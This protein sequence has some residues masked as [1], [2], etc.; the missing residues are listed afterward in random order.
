MSREGLEG[1]QN[2]AWVT[3]SAWRCG[4]LTNSVPRSKVMNRRAT[5][6]RSLMA[7]MILAMTG[8]VRLFGFFRITVKRLTRSTNEV[9]LDW[10]SFYLNSIKS[11]SQ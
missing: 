4:Q 10:P 3:I 1:S 9:T 11:A 7:L 5:R 6:E 8:L 2:H